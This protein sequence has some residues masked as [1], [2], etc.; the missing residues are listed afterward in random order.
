VEY[1]DSYFLDKYKDV[2]VK[3]YATVN[4]ESPAW[5]IDRL[6]ILALKIYHMHL[7]DC[8]RRCN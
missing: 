3:P 8:K 2:E 1:I 5:A 6:S 4:S 7:R